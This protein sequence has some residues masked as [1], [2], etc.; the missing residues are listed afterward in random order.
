M[1]GTVQFGL[2]YGIANKAGQPSLAN[3]RDILACAYEGGVNALDTAAAYGES[4]E[5]LGKAL[6]ELKI[7]D[8]MIIETK[9][10]HL[11]PEYSSAKAVDEVVEES[12]VRSLKRLRLERLP[13]CLF[14]AEENYQYIE[15]LLKLKDKGLVEHVGS[16]V[17]TPAATRKI[18]ESGYAQAIQ[19]PTNILDH[20]FIDEGI[21][22]LAKKLKAAV[23]VRSIYL[24]GLILMPENEI[25]PE[26]KDVIPVRRKLESLAA[27]AGMSLAELAVRYVLAIDGA[28]CVLV[29]VDTV[30]QMRENITMFS[31]GPLDQELMN[32]VTQAVPTLSDVILMPNKWSKRM[33]APKIER[34]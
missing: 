22:S 5:V 7:A 26:L 34:R 33:A 24:Q 11:A 19:V 27:E 25:L 12:V 13:I 14:H 4:E 2:N 28:G 18:L 20:R 1:L 15:S 3:V 16:S 17:M 8:K 21:F 30:D 32:A 23:F 10:A 9:V 29:G 6:S 31:K